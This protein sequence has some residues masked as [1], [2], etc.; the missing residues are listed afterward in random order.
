MQ[1]WTWKKSAF[2][3]AKVQTKRRIIYHI[4][5]KPWLLLLYLSSWVISYL[6]IWPILMRSPDAPCIIISIKFNYFCIIRSKKKCRS[7]VSDLFTP[8]F[9]LLLIALCFV[10][11]S[12]DLRDV[13]FDEREVHVSS[14]DQLVDQSYNTNES[15]H[16]I[17]VW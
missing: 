6:W 12:L 11:I 10:F 5:Y 16:Y 3:W 4:W 7:E 2:F 15:I 1:K 13:L 17:S 9:F 8:I 14:G